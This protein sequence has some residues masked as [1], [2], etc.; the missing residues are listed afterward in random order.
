MR[1][2]E[3]SDLADLRSFLDLLWNSVGETCE[4][5]VILLILDRSQDDLANSFFFIHHKWMEIK[6]IYHKVLILLQFK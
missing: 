1:L 5:T 3:I 6:Q 4:M 2:C